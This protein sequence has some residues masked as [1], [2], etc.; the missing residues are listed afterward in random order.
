[1]EHKAMNDSNGGGWAGGI[2]KAWSSSS[3]GQS[4]KSIYPW[5]KH[6]WRL[7][8]H[9]GA[10]IPFYC[11]ITAYVIFLFPICNTGLRM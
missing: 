1:M 5:S 8:S 10:I 9:K 3:K 2:R 4:F 11:C 6:T 7:Q